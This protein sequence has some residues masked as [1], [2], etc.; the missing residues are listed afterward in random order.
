MNRQLVLLER[1]AL[2]G[3]RIAESLEA[4]RS[5]N[6]TLAASVARL[7]DHLA[8]T[9]SALVGTRHVAGALGQTTTWVADMAR[10]GTIPK[11]CVVP[12]TGTGKPWKFYRD[13]IDAWL[14]SR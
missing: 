8:P 12:G 10:K 3:E 9:P 4:I 5:D 13:K 2:A 11:G 1:L 7:A 6:H 14:K